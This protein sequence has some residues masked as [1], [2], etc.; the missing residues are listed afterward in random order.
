MIYR[1]PEALICMKVLDY[2]LMEIIE[3]VHK[4]EYRDRDF[5]KFNEMER[6]ILPHYRLGS[7]T[8]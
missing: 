3:S 1:P 7:I 8:L 5:R 2:S 4:N 6:F